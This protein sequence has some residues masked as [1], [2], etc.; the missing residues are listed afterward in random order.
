[1]RFDDAQHKD[2]V[3]INVTL[4]GTQHIFVCN[5][6]DLNLTRKTQISSNKGGS[7]TLLVIVCTLEV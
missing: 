1:M 2:S 3:D 4:L 6:K 7:A 5:S